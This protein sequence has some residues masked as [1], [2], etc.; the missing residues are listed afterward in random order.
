MLRPSYANVNCTTTPSGNVNS[1]ISY[2]RRFSLRTF[3]S[4]A[5]VSARSGPVSSSMKLPVE[6]SGPLPGLD[7]T[8]GDDTEIEVPRPGPTRP[9][10]KT[11]RARGR[12]LELLTRT[13]NGIRTRA[14]TLRG[15]CPR[16]LDD[17]G[18]C[19]NRQRADCDEQ[20]RRTPLLLSCVRGGGL[21]PPMTGPEPVVLPITPSP[22]GAPRGDA[23]W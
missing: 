20:R 8:L 17:G 7:C 15:W 5:A 19:C 14:A 4:D 12:S 23:E 18:L 16:P 10:T 3:R 9:T 6:N 13:P 11:R 1:D 2:P 21:E 22:K